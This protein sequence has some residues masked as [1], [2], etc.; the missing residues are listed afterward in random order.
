M[1]M[2]HA[3][4]RARLRR[5]AQVLPAAAASQHHECAVHRVGDGSPVEIS[6][7]SASE[8]SAPPPPNYQ[9]LPHLSVLYVLQRGAQSV[10]SRS[11]S[12]SCIGSICGSWGRANCSTHASSP[13][14]KAG[15]GV[16]R[17]LGILSSYDE[18]LGRYI[19]GCDEA[20]CEAG[21]TADLGI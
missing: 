12:C 15:D 13:M 11:T 3:D 5:G 21:R 19:V 6:A 18:L 16:Q 9:S 10:M 1:L 17:Q 20:V 4:D 2:R 8:P 14:S 7:C